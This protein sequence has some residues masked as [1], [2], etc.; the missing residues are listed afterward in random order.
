M[1]SMNVV[2]SVCLFLFFY[3]LCYSLDTQLSTALSKTFVSYEIISPLVVQP[4]CWECFWYSCTDLYHKW[5]FFPLLCPKR[6]NILYSN[7]EALGF[8]WLALSLYL[9]KYI[10]L[11]SDVI[12]WPLQPSSFLFLFVCLFLFLFYYYFCN[13]YLR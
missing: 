5:Y 6:E 13:I 4:C 10:R 12:K 2:F 11:F 1:T 7:F 3:L 8:L 9:W